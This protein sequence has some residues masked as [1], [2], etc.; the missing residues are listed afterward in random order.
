MAS[1]SPSGLGSHHSPAQK[2]DLTKATICACPTRH[3]YL[4][5]KNH[6]INGKNQRR[7]TGKKSKQTKW[8]PVD[9][10]KKEP[11]ACR[12]DDFVLRNFKE[13][14]SAHHIKPKRT[15]AWHLPKITL[16]STDSLQTNLNKKQNLEFHFPHDPEGAYLP[17]KPTLN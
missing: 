13:S 15:W 3:T 11:H 6:Q 1:S 9:Y 5:I 8:S 17:G 7:V 14:L 10:I 12:P 16:I 2:G 4:S